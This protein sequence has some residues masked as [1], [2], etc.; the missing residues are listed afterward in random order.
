M[1]IDMQVP[2]NLNAA[3][4][5][6]MH[7]NLTRKLT[8]DQP[9]LYIAALGLALCLYAYPALGFRTGGAKYEGQVAMGTP[10]Q[11]FEFA[12]KNGVYPPLDQQH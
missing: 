9:I 11:T 2:L 8:R 3:S 6:C 7:T 5:S 12:V 1:V 10:P 4:G